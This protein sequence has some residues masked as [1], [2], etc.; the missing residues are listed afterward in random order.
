MKLGIDCP[1]SIDSI[2]LISRKLRGMKTIKEHFDFICSLIGFDLEELAGAKSRKIN[3]TTFQ[4]ENK[5]LKASNFIAKNEDGFALYILRDIYEAVFGL[6]TDDKEWILKNTESF[7]EFVNSTKAINAQCDEWLKGLYQ[8]KLNQFDSYKAFKEGELTSDKISPDIFIDLDESLSKNLLRAYRFRGKGKV[9][10]PTQ[11]SI[12]DRLVIINSL[13]EFLTTIPSNKELTVYFL[14]KAESRI[15]FSYFLIVISFGDHVWLISDMNEFDNPR[16]KAT[17]RNAYRNRERAFEM[18]GFPYYLI[19][20]LQEKRSNTREVVKLSQK[21]L[22]FLSKPVIDLHEVSKVF[23][24]YV[25]QYFI[26]NIHTVKNEISIMG[27][28]ADQLLLGDGSDGFTVDATAANSAFE[29]W[30]DHIR[31]VHSDLINET[32]RLTGKSNELIQVKRDLIT[33]NPMFDR[34][35]LASPEKLKNILEWT[36]LDSQR[37]KLQKALDRKFSENR[38]RD[39]EH[40]LTRALNKKAVLQRLIP[41]LFC[42]ENIYFKIKGYRRTGSSF[43]E[44]KQTRILLF[45]S[46]EKPAIFSD[47]H[48]WFDRDGVEKRSKEWYSNLTIKKRWTRDQYIWDGVCQLCDQGAKATRAFKVHVRHYE[49]LIYLLGGNDQ[50]CL[51]DY[52]RVYR[53]HDFVPYSGNSILDNTHPM[54]LLEHPSWDSFANGIDIVGHVC[55][56]CYARLMKEHRIADAVIIADGKLGPYEPPSTNSH[57]STIRL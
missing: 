42:A 4:I 25:T 17:T 49:Q 21:D 48:L 26:E 18:L 37:E 8:Q 20:E 44:E 52:F 13:E 57:K 40:V 29:G 38:K 22:E 45:R 56:K 15:D 10:L 7:V 6:V 28:V 32:S 1:E 35:W 9:K 46:L 50:D 55:K 34:D 39:Q 47:V 31:D 36:A 16:N 54:A 11:Y 3:L 5:L 24:L 30:D 41:I 43:Y 27:T 2:D 33:K 12:K 53:A 51:P 19:D 14:L 23:M